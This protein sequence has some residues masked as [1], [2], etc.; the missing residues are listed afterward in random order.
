MNELVVKRASIFALI[1]GATIGLA[2]LIPTLIGLGLFLLSLLVAPIVMIFMSKDEK[3]LGILNNEQGAI[4]GGFIG[5]FSTIGFFAAFSPMVCIL[6]L[7]F[8]N[9]YS[10]TIPDMLNT[11]SWLFF[12]IVFMVAFIFALT[13]A[14]SGM[15][16]I[17]LMNKINK[18]PQ[19]DNA[20]LNIEIDD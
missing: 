14:A 3:H 10:Y 13:N 2:S 17:Y 16:I 6:H 20:Q 1:L 12:V 5:F 9:Y 7:I 19:E 4:L 8:K 18:N 11:A 15:G